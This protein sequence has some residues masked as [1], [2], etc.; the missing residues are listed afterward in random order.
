MNRGGSGTRATQ[1]ACA[2]V[3]QLRLGNACLD[4]QWLTSAMTDVAGRG[5]PWNT[6]CVIGVSSGMTMGYDLAE[7]GA[8]DVIDT[9]C[10]MVRAR[11]S[12]SVCAR[13]A[14]PTSH[15]TA[16]AGFKTKRRLN[17][18]TARGTPRHDRQYTRNT[19]KQPVFARQTN[20][21][22][23]RDSRAPLSSRRGRAGCRGPCRR[24]PLVHGRVQRIATRKTGRAPWELQLKSLTDLHLAL[25]L[26]PQS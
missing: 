11:C 2:R 21:Q 23:R 1:Y 9:V 16:A 14:A 7:L 25:N 6:I 18:N 15:G 22:R 26:S 3:P 24:V 17:S 10:H 19:H 20:R 4:C 13:L 5:A 8:S 12:V